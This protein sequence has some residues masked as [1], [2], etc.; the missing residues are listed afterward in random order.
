[1]DTVLLETKR[2]YI[3]EYKP[4]MALK[5]SQGTLDED[6]R[7]FLPDE[8]FETEEEA[9]RIA[10]DTIYG[11]QASLFTDDLTTAHRVSRALRAGTVSVNCYAE[12]DIGTPFGGFKQSGFMSR[13]NSVWA[14]QQFTELKTIWM[15]L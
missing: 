15:K 3:G 4:D 10:N 13:D 12:G 9:I 7:K 8:V 14:N 6:T 11:L 2:L 5:V 1:M